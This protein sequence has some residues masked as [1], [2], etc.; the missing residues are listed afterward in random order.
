MASNLKM[1]SGWSIIPSCFMCS[2]QILDQELS[3]LFHGLTI[4]AEGRYCITFYIAVDKICNASEDTWPD[5]VI[6][7]L[8]PQK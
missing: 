7:G 1:E 4:P 8:E 6:V 5:Y 3:F 2:L